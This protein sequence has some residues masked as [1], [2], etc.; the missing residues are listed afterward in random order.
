MLCWNKTSETKG[1]MNMNFQHSE[2]Y[3]VKGLEK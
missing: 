3:L 1:D 2:Y